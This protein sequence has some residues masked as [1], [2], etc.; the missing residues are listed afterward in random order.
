MKK[1]FTPIAMKCSKEQFKEIKLKLK[2]IGKFGNLTGAFKDYEYLTNNYEN[3]GKIFFDFIGI[4]SD[5]K[6]EHKNNIHK[7]WNEKVFL[8]AC[9]IET[10]P[11]YVIT[12]EQIKKLLSETHKENESSLKEW[13]PDAFKED[14]VELEVGKWYK[15]PNIGSLA[16][17]KEILD[18]KSFYGYGFGS[19]NSG[20][21]WFDFS[22]V[23]FTCSNWKEA[24]PKEVTEALTKEAVKRYKVGDY[25]NKLN[26]FCYGREYK[27][28]EVTNIEFEY[29][30]YAGSIF[31]VSDEGFG[32]GV[33]KNGKWVEI[34]ETISKDE[35]EK[36]IGKKIL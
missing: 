36:I 7:T 6:S 11:E 13:F 19:D 15:N 34:L 26:N 27:Y 22:D 16:F 3:K 31:F 33:F 21:E 12:K 20:N 32:I 2:K 35:A 29:C 17:C 23:E 28:Y 25:V 8:S 4:D 5:W 30:K 1:E 9:G 18:K 10:E 24:T 14:K